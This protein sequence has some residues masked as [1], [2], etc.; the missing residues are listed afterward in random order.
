M[1]NLRINPKLFTP[2]KKNCLR[3]FGHIESGIDTTER[4][5][6]EG[7]VDEEKIPYTFSCVDGIRRYENIVKPNVQLDAYIEWSRKI[8]KWVPLREEKENG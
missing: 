5:I 1:G 7:N 2:I 4:L 6:V 8:F 3:Y